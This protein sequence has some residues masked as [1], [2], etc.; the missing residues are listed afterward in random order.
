MSANYFIVLGICGTSGSGKT[1]LLEAV[2]PKLRE[3]GLTV[4]VIKHSHHDLQLDTPG[5]DSFRHRQAGA[6]E[7]M[8]VSPHRFGLFADTAAELT[9]D[10]QLSRLS[11]CDLVLLEGHKAQ[12]VPKL[13]IHR[14]AL[15]KPPLFESDPSIIA[16]ASDGAL[17]APCLV[18]DLNDPSAVARFIMDWLVQRKAASRA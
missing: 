13:E 11:P 17:D 15:G 2:L 3:A 5:K 16:V 4:S 8:V 10:Q 12:P 1:T 9:L 6:A 7:V 14:P 18:L